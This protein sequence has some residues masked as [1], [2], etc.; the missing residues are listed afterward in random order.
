MR[1]SIELN[2][3]KPGVIER[4]ALYTIDEAADRLSDRGHKLYAACALRTKRPESRTQIA[5]M[6]K[7]GVTCVS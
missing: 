3:G 6:T 4:D 5:E 2:H 7:V 1:K